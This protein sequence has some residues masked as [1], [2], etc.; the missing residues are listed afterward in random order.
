MFHGQCDKAEPF[1]EQLYLAFAE[2]PRLTQ[3][4]SFAKLH[5]LTQT[6]A[7]Y[8]YSLSFQK[9]AARVNVDNFTKMTLFCDG[10]KPE[11]SIHLLKL[12]PKPA[13]LSSLIKVAIKFNDAIFFSKPKD[14]PPV[15]SLSSTPNFSFASFQNKKNNFFFILS[16]ERGE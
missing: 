16:T 14:P 3:D 15:T 6:K 13:T 9:L 11:I 2:G 1:L 10:L 4:M 5:C 12:Q 7:S 8:E